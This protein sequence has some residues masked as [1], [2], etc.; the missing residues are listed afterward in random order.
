MTFPMTVKNRSKKKQIKFSPSKFALLGQK[1]KILCEEQ[2]KRKKPTRL[3]FI[4]WQHFC[5]LFPTVFL[6]GWKIKHSTDA[7]VYLEIRDS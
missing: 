5:L 7:Y 3:V 2:L 1:S 4:F 6:Y